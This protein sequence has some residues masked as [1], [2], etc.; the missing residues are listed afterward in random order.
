[1]LDMQSVLRRLCERV[2]ELERQRVRTNRGHLNQ[3]RAADYLNKSREW[4]RQR[5]LRGDG[6]RRNPDGTYPIDGLDEFIEQNT[7][8]T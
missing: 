2:D 1:M 4:L 3:R 8:R 7:G 5:D 6:P